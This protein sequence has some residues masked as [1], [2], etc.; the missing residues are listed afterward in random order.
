MHFG[1]FWNYWNLGHKVTFDPALR[2]I[3]VNDG[4]T[5]L[6]ILI[7]IYSA[8][9]EWLHDEETI[10]YP[11][12]CRAVGGDPIPGGSTGSTFFLINDW[13]LLIDLTAVRVSGVLFS[14]SFSTA[15]Y[16]P[17]GDP[18]YPATVSSLVNQVL[19][20]TNVVTGDVNSVPAN[21]WNYV[22][23]PSPPEGSGADTVQRIQ[24]LAQAILALTA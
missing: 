4:V 20:P 12:P 15:Y 2:A 14:D 5:D 18:V 3:I 7:D 13:K 8:S 16:S 24:A 11:P 6:D 17:E 10:H 19:V 21:V 1:G 22:L 23:S 9:K